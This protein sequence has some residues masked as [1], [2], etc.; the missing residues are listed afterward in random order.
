M[1]K[2]TQSIVSPIAGT[3]MEQMYDENLW[4]TGL[5]MNQQ[6]QQLAHNLREI[7]IAQ[8]RYTYYLT[9]MWRSVW[10]HPLRLKKII[11]AYYASILFI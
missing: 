11:R 8:G 9:W 6:T 7:Q 3:M 5:T 2:K 10:F 4:Q 1:S